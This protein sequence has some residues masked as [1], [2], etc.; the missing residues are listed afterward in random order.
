VDRAGYEREMEEAKKRARGARK[1]MVITAVQGDLPKTDDSPKYGGLSTTAKVL[2]WV[3][4][5][6]VARSGKLEEDVEVALLL[7]RTNFYAEQ[8]GQV[9]DIGAITTPTGR[10]EVDDSQKL[11][12]SVLHVGH[13]VEGKIEPGQEGFLEVAGIRADTMRNHTA[14]HLLNW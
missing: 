14:T 5:N 2:G 7:D 6:A 8:G 4:D 13:L 12:D 9:G 11:G 1:K 10:F 3:K